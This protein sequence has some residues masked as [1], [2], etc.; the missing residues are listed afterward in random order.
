MCKK[1]GLYTIHKFSFAKILFQI[2]LSTLSIV[3][4]G[5]F[6]KIFPDGVQS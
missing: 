5:K 1:P 4:T 3:E 2:I 6:L